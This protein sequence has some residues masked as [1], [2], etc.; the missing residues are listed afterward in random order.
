VKKE[1]LRKQGQIDEKEAD[2]VA[3]GAIT[4]GCAITGRCAISGGA[5]AIG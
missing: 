5:C 1:A 4:G 3:G 2:N